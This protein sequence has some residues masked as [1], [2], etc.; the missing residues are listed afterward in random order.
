MGASGD[1]KNV[2]SRRKLRG[3]R[4][5][6]RSLSLLELAETVGV[7]TASDCRAGVCLTCKVRVLAGE[8]TADLGDGTALLC[9]G[10]PKTDALVVDA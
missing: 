1:R 6:Y 8:T 9:I 5:R 2:F 7:E 4:G 3:Y 10:R